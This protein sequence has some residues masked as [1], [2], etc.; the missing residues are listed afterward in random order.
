MKQPMAPA[1][2]GLGF[3]VGPEFGH[4]RWAHSG[5]MPGVAT[6][7]NIYPDE[8]VVIVVLANTSTRPERIAQDIAAIML[9]RYADSLAARRSR[10][11]PQAP[12]TFAPGPS[13][14]GEWTGTLTTWQRPV[15]I[16]LTIRENGDAFAWVGDQPRAVLN[17]LVFVNN[18]LT[19]R[20]AG[21]IGTEDGGRWPH[22]L[23]LGL[24]LVDGALKG[25]VSAQTST[26]PVYYSLAS[27]AEL[28]RKQ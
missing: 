26:D 21:Q 10:P 2:Y 23:Q 5:G 9:P 18:R 20:F 1:S 16:R 6:A 17:Q 25:Q 12:A 11:A 22:S 3:A 8:S 4:L 27:Y 14:I 13:L 24:Q 15:P 19:G 7:M 28:T